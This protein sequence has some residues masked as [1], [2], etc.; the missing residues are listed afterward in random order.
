MIEDFCDNLFK[1]MCYEVKWCSWFISKLFPKLSFRY[2][3]QISKEEINNALQEVDKELG[4]T[5]F[6]AESNIKTNVP[7]SHFDDRRRTCFNWLKDNLPHRYHSDSGVRNDKVRR[8]TPKL[9]FFSFFIWNVLFFLNLPHIL[10][11][12][13]N[14]P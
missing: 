2:R 5:L 13:P 12:N 7:T 4:Q 11:I 1:I 6:V 14:N 8:K 10:I 9:I 3:I